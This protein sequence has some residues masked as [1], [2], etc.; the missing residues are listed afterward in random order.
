L[1]QS[2]LYRFTTVF[3]EGRIVLLNFSIRHFIQDPYF[4][5]VPEISDTY[6]TLE[7]PCEGLF[8]DRGSKFLAYAYPVSSEE[9]IKIR[10][11][12]VRKLHHSARHHCYA[13]RFGF[14]K[15]QRER[16]NDDGEPSNS[17]GKPILG[18]IESHHL[19]EVLIIVVRYFGGV[20][21]GVGGLINAY[22]SA[23]ADAIDEGKV[24]EKIVTHRIRVSFGYDRMSAVMKLVKDERLNQIKQAFDMNCDLDLE[25]RWAD[26]DRIY[27]QFEKMDGVKAKVLNAE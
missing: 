26:L 11:E 6:L 25:V 12:E 19:N 22:R 10:Q 3:F 8:K 23:A 20:K 17:A 21:L 9:D 13:W 18:Q 14:E 7:G 15:Q 16:A 27:E 1:L 4:C 24:I 2:E 5:A